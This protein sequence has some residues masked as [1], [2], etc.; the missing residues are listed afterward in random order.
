MIKTCRC[1]QGVSAAALV[2]FTAAFGAAWAVHLVTTN[3]RRRRALAAVT[4]T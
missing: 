3:V 2:L 1:P 4:E